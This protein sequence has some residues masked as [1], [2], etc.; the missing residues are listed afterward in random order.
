MGQQ[1]EKIA[2]LPHSLEEASGMVFIQ[3]FGLYLLDDT[4]SPYVYKVCEKTGEILQVIEIKGTFFK[5]K[6]ALTAD[7]DFL[8]VGD[9]GDNKGNRKSLKIIKIP[10]SELKNN[11]DTIRVVGQEIN[12]SI[13]GKKKP[14]RK[15]HN[16][17][18]FEAF[19]VMSDSIYLLSKRRPDY[20]TALYV[21]PNKIGNQTAVLKCKLDVNGLIT[22]AALHPDKKQLVLIGYQKRK[23]NPYLIHFK[24]WNLCNTSNEDIKYIPI[25]TDN[26][27]FQ[28]EAIT[29]INE[30]ELL[31]SNEWTKDFEQA[32]YRIVLN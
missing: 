13:A 19:F 16:I 3:K 11:L 12:I 4:K 7:D 15:K 25:V 28:G 1:E 22:G 5:D 10:L 29:F 31:F 17:Y 32:L 30:N 20:K 2:V 18:D 27:S 8:Y 14:K 24:N 9:I 26:L 23:K 21:M 6:E